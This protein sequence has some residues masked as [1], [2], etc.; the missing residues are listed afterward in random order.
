MKTL[1]MAIETDSEKWLDFVKIAAA[2]LAPYFLVKSWIDKYWKDKSL[3]RDAALQII[4]NQTI[5][6]RV[7]PEIK[8]MTESIDKLREVVVDLQLKANNKL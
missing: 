8:R 2:C 1:N 5:D 4:I 3:E 7:M 6:S